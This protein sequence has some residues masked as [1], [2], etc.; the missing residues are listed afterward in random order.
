MTPDV[1]LHRDLLPVCCESMCKVEKLFDWAM[2]LV[3]AEKP[4]KSHVVLT[5]LVTPVKPDCLTRRLL[6]S[7]ETMMK[8]GRFEL[9]MTLPALYNAATTR[10]EI[11]YTLV[12]AALCI[13]LPSVMPG[14]ATVQDNVHLVD[15]RL[16]QKAVSFSSA[17]YV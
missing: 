7:S 8:F 2:L 6:E 12:N 1:C 4:R 11:L 3:Q 16:F 5:T 9:H 10:G 15:R 13:F 17:G 14:H